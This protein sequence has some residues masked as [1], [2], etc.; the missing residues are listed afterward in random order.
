MVSIIDRQENGEADAAMKEANL[1]LI[2]LFT[3]QDL[4]EDKAPVRTLKRP[5]MMVN[6]ETN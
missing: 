4:I 5:T 3:L 1:E 6:Y 2:S